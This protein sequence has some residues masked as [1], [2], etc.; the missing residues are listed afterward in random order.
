[1]EKVGKK[2]GKVWNRS[3]NQFEVPS[4]PPKSGFFW[5]IFLNFLR[6]KGLGPQRLDLTILRNNR[7]ILVYLEPNQW[8]E[9][10]KNVFLRNFFG[11]KV[12]PDRKSD[13]RRFLVRSS[14][15]R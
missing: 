14:L 6:I 11:H 5:K 13:G 4:P 10:E 12:S 15:V 2:C 7:P 9:I 8:L 3:K 1:M